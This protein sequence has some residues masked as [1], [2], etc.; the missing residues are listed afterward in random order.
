MSNNKKTLKHL[1]QLWEAAQPPETTHS[2]LAV[3]VY[4]AHLL[5]RSFFAPAKANAVA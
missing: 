3:L 1:I 2:G 4:E 5:L